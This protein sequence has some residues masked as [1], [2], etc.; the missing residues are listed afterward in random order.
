MNGILLLLAS[1]LLRD[2]LRLVMAKEFC[3]IAE[4]DE[5]NLVRELD[6]LPA[7]LAC[8]IVD[9]IALNRNTD[10][11]TSSKASFCRIVILANEADLLEMSDDHVAL[12][13][14]ILTHELSVD[15][16]GAI[17]PPRLRGRTSD[18]AGFAADN[19]ARTA[20]VEV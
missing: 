9:P 11:I 8:V 1:R 12:A 13:D 20:A 10:L 4:I 18:F 7:S 3:I 16:V 15:A 6:N 17:A 19:R 2:S 14:G 5:N